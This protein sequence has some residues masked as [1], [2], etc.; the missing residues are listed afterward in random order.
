MKVTVSGATG[1]IGRALVRELRERGDE[2]IAL[3]RDP[4]RAAASLG[5][6][7]QAWR[8]P[9]GEPPPP[10]SLRGSDAVAHLLGETVAQ[11]WTEAAKREI[12]DSRILST[13]QLVAGLAELA[14][15]ERPRVLVSQSATGFYGPRGDERLS[16]EAAAGDDFLAKVV[17]DWEA[18]AQRA[19]ELDM[20]V[21][22]TRT[23]VVLSEQGGAL[24]KML[25]FFKLGIGGPVAGGKQYVPWVHLDDVVGA[26]VACIDGD[27]SGPVN[28]TAAEPATNRELSKTLGKVLK[29]PAFAPVPGLAVEALYGEMAMIVTTGQR[30]VPARL[31]ESG[32]RFRRPSLEA[33]L[34]A[35]V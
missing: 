21:V 33:A 12:R 15:Q 13:R 14:P 18:E 11:R 32:Y 3:S 2:V 31:E 26:L 4:E 8:D 6:E 35:T 22:T 17:R 1:M 23:G 29:R 34:R 20:R 19:V 5:V 16:E 30:A 7:A 25:P 27:L 10:D 24:E 28:V 9:K